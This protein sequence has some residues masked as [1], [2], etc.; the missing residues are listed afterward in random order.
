MQIEFDEKADS[1]EVKRL[2]IAALCRHAIKIRLWEDV[3]ARLKNIFQSSPGDPL[4]VL[5][6][7]MIGEAVP[8]PSQ[9]NLVNFSQF[10]NLLSS[11]IK[12]LGLQKLISK[13]QE[14]HVYQFERRTLLGY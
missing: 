8:N 12:F 1:Y 14:N 11:R 10:L 13:V 5:R 7:S 3:L 2:I 4:H 9:I 6:A